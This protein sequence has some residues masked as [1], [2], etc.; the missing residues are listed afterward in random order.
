PIIIGIN[1]VGFDVARILPPAT[2]TCRTAGSVTCNFVELAPGETQ[3]LAVTLVP[4]APGTFSITGWARSSYIAG[5]SLESRSV[6][7]P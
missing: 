1:R 3:S 2:G 5:G 4:S 6:T 7:V